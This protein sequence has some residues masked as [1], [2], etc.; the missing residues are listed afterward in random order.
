M[1]GD[2]LDVWA[3]RL[4]RV[5]D[6][7]RDLLVDHIDRT[8]TELHNALTHVAASRVPLDGKLAEIALQEL[9]QGEDQVRVRP[10]TVIA[11]T[12]EFF[13]ATV[14]ELRGAMRGSNSLARARQIAVYLCR[15][16]TDISLS[17]IGQEF[18]RDHTTVMHAVRKIRREIA[19]VQ[20]TSEQVGDLTGLIKR[21]AAMDA[22]RHTRD[23]HNPHGSTRSMLSKPS[24]QRAIQSSPLS[25]IRFPV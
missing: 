1:S 18:G 7:T 16:L 13:G 5:L 17:R 25:T 15:E 4:H 2:L 24:D 8:I 21:H 23:R 22:L 20:C 11:V 19:E 12:A 9:V 3:A 14:E 6:E 10:G